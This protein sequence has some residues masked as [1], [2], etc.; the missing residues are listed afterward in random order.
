MGDINFKHPF[1]G[2]AEE[3]AKAHYLRFLDWCGN[4]NL[5]N[6]PHMQEAAKIELFK[7]TLAE[8]ARIWYDSVVDTLLSSAQMEEEFKKKFS[9]YGQT[10]M[11]L[12]NSWRSLRWDAG[13]ESIE[14]FSNR[15]K[16]LG[17]LTHQSD[18]QILNEF[19]RA[20]PPIMYSGLASCQTLAEAV[21]MATNTASIFVSHGMA[22]S[23]GLPNQ[24]GAVPALGTAPTLG[25]VEVTSPLKRITQPPQG[26][27]FVAEQTEN[28]GSSDLDE[29]KEMLNGIME[30]QSQHDPKKQNFQ[31]NTDKRPGNNDRTNKVFRNKND[32]CWGCGQ[33]GHIRRNCPS[34]PQPPPPYPRYGPPRV[35]PNQA[36]LQ[37]MKGKLADNVLSR[38]NYGLG[39]NVNF[40]SGQNSRDPPGRSDDKPNTFHQATEVAP[41]DEHYAT[42]QCDR[43]MA[44]ILNEIGNIQAQCAIESGDYS[45]M[46]LCMMQSGTPDSDSD[47]E[48]VEALTQAGPSCYASTALR[49]P[50]TNDGKEIEQAKENDQGDNSQMQAQ[51]DVYEDISDLSPAARRRNKVLDIRESLKINLINS[52]ESLSMEQITMLASQILVGKRFDEALER[53]CEDDDDS[54]VQQVSKGTRP[55]RPCTQD[56]ECPTPIKA[57]ANIGTTFKALKT[58]SV[59]RQ[60]SLP[61]LGTTTNYDGTQPRAR[62]PHSNS[63]IELRATSDPHP[64][65]TL[66]TNSGAHCGGPEYSS[67]AW[68]RKGIRSKSPLPSRAKSL[69]DQAPRMGVRMLDQRLLA[70]S[71]PS[72]RD[73]LP[74]LK[75]GGNT[76]HQIEIGPPSPESRSDYALAEND[77]D[78][79][80]ESADTAALT[81]KA[82]RQLYRAD[83][84]S[85][86]P[87][88]PSKRLS[89]IPEM[90]EEYDQGYIDDYAPP[91]DQLHLM[92]QGVRIDPVQR[93]SGYE[94]NYGIRK[95]DAEGLR[96]AQ[97]HFERDQRLDIKKPF[98][99]EFFQ[100]DAREQ[101]PS[102]YGEEGFATMYPPSRE[103]SH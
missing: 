92:D 24:L 15:V 37:H 26:K 65:R 83:Y 102:P 58:P 9:K 91:V 28:A 86:T 38:R 55:S 18:E 54:K 48:E 36:R 20:M 33:Y 103:N 40:R 19:I 68:P 6:N 12:T 57:Q 35:S 31:S 17:R 42:E 25:A 1:K 96:Q 21:K 47:S 7:H 93:S 81:V 88:G 76:H 90:P 80:V 10:E 13:Q 64:E 29:I 63:S 32:G 87:G 5:P 74:N 43:E 71:L 3:S 44:L 22:V 11:E 100:S 101:L 50:P 59:E 75:K 98:P 73:S 45:G 97:T 53:F 27:L 89:Y 49:Y 67:D 46:S 62:L 16:D 56:I 60:Q 95:N 34:T 61:G 77:L 99:A 30:R 8:E 41:Y 70:D 39:L 4:F 23:Q 72:F 14:K 66:A 69:Q 52:L 82:G 51:E 2:T 78:S 79:P 84:V 94:T 85:R